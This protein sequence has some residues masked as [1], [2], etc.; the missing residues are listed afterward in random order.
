MKTLWIG[1]SHSA[2]T[3]DINDRRVTTNGIPEETHKYFSNHTVWKSVSCSGEGLIRY[4]TILSYLDKHDML[5][6]FDNLI[7]QLTSETRL[8][9]Y[10]NFDS[11]VTAF[12]EL[13]KYLKSNNNSHHI[14][15]S[16]TAFSCNPYELYSIH[17]QGYDTKNKA[18]LL[19]T[20]EQ[21]IESLLLELRLQL[22]IHC[23]NILNII[24]RNGINF[25][26]Y[27]HIRDDNVSE[28]YTDA[29]KKYDIFDSSPIGQIL[30]HESLSEN[31]ITATC[32]PKAQGVKD[33]AR[34]VADG[35]SK[36]GMK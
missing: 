1:C 4:S 14:F 3:Y 34:V 13:N 15:A 16:K 35:L 30:E 12:T 22:S 33:A 31:F 36:A 18:K 27:S 25:Y 7:L 24:E 19:G 23:N 26:T 20:I 29:F 5:R 10:D 2:G 32:H 11:Y 17:E 21:L 8:A 9:A 6:N 28:L